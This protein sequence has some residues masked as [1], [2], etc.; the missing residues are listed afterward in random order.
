MFPQF[1]QKILQPHLSTTQ[2]LTLQLLVLVL[3]SVKNVSL[4]KLAQ[5]FPQ[6]IKAASRVRSLQRFLNLSQLRAEKLWW[7][8]VKE[9]VKAESVKPSKKRARLFHQGYLLLV[10]AISYTLCTLQGIAGQQTPVNDYLAR[11]TEKSRRVERHS[12]FYLGCYGF[13]WISSFQCWSQLAEQLMQSKAHKRYFYARGLQALS[14][15]QSTL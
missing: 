1:Y 6:P 8:I 11:P 7:P 4:S 15:I 13:S 14:L 9:L 12:N 10:M 5:R 2:Y 3:Q